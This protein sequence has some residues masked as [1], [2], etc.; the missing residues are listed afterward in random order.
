[1][2]KD[3]ERWMKEDPEDFCD[4]EMMKKWKRNEEMVDLTF[5]PKNIQ[6]ETLKQFNEQ[7]GGDRSKLFNYFVKMKLKNLMNSLQEY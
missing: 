4:E 1:M 6:E 3:L 7:E 2:K 5:I